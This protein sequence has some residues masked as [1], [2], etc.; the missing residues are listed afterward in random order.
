MV[1]A[2]D[3]TR[4][5]VQALKRPALR[6]R[7]HHRRR[8]LPLDR[9]PGAR[10]S[11]LADKGIGF[12]DC[13]VSGGVWGLENGY[14]LMA[15]GDD[16]EHRDRPADLRRAQARGR[17]RLGA[18]RQGGRRALLQDG[19]QRH[20]VRHHAGVRRGLGAAP[21]GRRGRQRHRGVPLLARG[22]RDPVLAARPA[23]RRARRRRRT[24]T[25]SRGY[26]EDSGEGRWTVEAG[27]DNAVATPA[28]TA[29]L[30]ARFVSRQ[31]D[32][33]AMKAV[34]AMRNQFGGPRHAR[35]A[36]RPAATRPRSPRP[37]ARLPPVAARLPVLPRGRGRA[38]SRGDRVRRPQRAGQDQPGRGGRLH[39]PARP[40]TGS[41]AT[42]R[43]SGSA[44]TTPS[45]GRPWSRTAARRCSR[46]RSTRAGPTRPG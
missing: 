10:A 25:R 14:A 6:G 45:S 29:A 28:I 39:R 4:E 38:R 42:P 36:R 22:H 13:G 16:G 12:V 1:P 27:I 18:R 15:G 20:R 32:S 43:W 17:V 5:T 19:P 8:Q 9:R 31:D 35:P 7:H 37:R 41:P 46:C 30:Y 21:G 23:G 3:P 44:P 33:P 34:A 24:W 26:A 40:R 2:G 11:M